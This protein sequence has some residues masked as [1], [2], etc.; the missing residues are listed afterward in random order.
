[1][2]W[3][4]SR[5]TLIKLAEQAEVLESRFLQNFNVVA[6]PTFVDLT[7]GGDCHHSNSQ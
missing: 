2:S 3:S 4:I 1:M 6:M 5:K 7:K